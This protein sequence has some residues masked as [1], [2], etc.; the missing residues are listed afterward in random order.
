MTRIRGLGTPSRDPL[1]RSRSV[2]AQRPHHQPAQEQDGTDS[3]QAQRDRHALRGGSTDH[4]D[5]CEGDQ[6]ADPP[7]RRLRVLVR[8]AHLPSRMKW[9]WL[10]LS[11]RRRPGPTPLAHYERGPGLEVEI[12][13]PQPGHLTDPHPRVEKQPDDRRVPAGGEVAALHARSSRASA[14]SSSTG[15]IRSPTA[16]GFMRSIGDRA[17]SPSSSR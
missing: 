10:A 13:D 14:S 1:I 4:E 3:D 17:I 2:A 7:R 16:G 6:Q 12:A 11:R 8:P 5:D 9:R 15:I